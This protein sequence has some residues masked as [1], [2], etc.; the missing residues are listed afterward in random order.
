MCRISDYLFNMSKKKTCLLDLEKTLSYPC[1]EKGSESIL[2]WV[3][4]VQIDPW[5]TLLPIMEADATA[6]AME[7][8]ELGNSPTGGSMALM[9]A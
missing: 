6:A 7:D 5:S 3:Q 4:R 1:Q 2:S 9:C 8:F